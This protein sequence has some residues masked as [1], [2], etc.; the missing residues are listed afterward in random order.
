[1][2]LTRLGTTALTFE[3]IEDLILILVSGTDPIS[4]LVCPA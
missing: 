4:L 2:S 3:K 1:M